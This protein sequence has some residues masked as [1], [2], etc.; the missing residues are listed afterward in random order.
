MVEF[1]SR[2]RRFEIPR[3]IMKRFFRDQRCHPHH[4]LV[5]VQKKKYSRPLAVT[6]LYLI[7][8]VRDERKLVITNF[9]ERSTR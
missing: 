5:A 8:H 1:N 4:T 7:S 2:A 9:S 3:R 6:N